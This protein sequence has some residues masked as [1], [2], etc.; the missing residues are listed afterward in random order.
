[1]GL[2]QLDEFGDGAKIISKMQIARRLHAGENPFNEFCHVR[3]TPGA[4]NI[5]VARNKPLRAIDARHM[6]LCQERFLIR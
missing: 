6:I 3:G 2:L 5:I 1:M 4:Q